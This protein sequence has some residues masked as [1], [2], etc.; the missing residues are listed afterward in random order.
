VAKQRGNSEGSI[1]KR[2]DG[3]WAASVDLGFIDGKRVRKAF[4]GAT[5]K[6]VSAKLT[7]ALG[8]QQRGAVVN[9][10]D[11][12]SV[13]AYLDRWLA[14]VSVRPKTKRQYEQVVR[15][16]LKPAIGPVRLARLEP[17]QVRAL[18]RGLEERGLSTRTATLARDVLRIALSQAVRDE[19]LARNVAMLVRRPKPT[20]RAGP[21]L[22]T[23]EARALLEAL[24]G[25]R[26]D[27][28]VTC[29]VA[30]GLRLGEVLGLQ[31]TDLDLAAARIAIRHALQTIGTRRTL[32]DLKSRESHRT[33]ALPAIVV[34]T[35][36]RHRRWQAERRLA[37]GDRWQPSEFVFTTRDGRP[38]LDTL[39][40]RDLKRI[41]A[42][43]WLGGRS[44]C[45]HT[46]HRD[47]ACLDCAATQLPIVSFH[48]L[49][50]S[51]ASLLLAAGVPIR[52]VSELLGHSDVRLTLA[53]YAHVLEVQRTKLAGTMD[54]VFDS[55]SDSYTGAR[56]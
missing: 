11:Q 2:Q 35:L 1:Y 24:A 52:D 23:D 12:I 41:L 42:Q 22:S 39:V 56:G 16:Y 9:T 14:T 31:W 18:V 33:L 3:R 44:D 47:R 34:R 17:D 49:R 4:Y 25:R 40:T 55:Q 6:A 48:G 20:R 38:L 7:T 32:V 13:G 10:N 37:A 43:T 19:V 15:L 36:Q 50:H 30:L 8:R 53:T 21:T 27:A 29:G 46:R 45:S 28:L 51:C 26:L 54:Q 5:R